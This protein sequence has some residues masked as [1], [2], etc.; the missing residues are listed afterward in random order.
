MKNQSKDNKDKLEI[1]EKPD[2]I[3]ITE[4]IKN[5]KSIKNIKVKI[6]K[7]LPKITKI[8]NQK[9]KKDKKCLLI[10]MTSQVFD[11]LT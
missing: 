2:N 10:K 9:Y 4:T 8:I 1:T 5:I 3:T 11:S 7:T 6:I